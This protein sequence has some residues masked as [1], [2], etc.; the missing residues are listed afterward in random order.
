MV[1]DNTET[2]DVTKVKEVVSESAE[3]VQ[4]AVTDDEI[5]FNQK[6]KII[7]KSQIKT[8]NQQMKI[9]K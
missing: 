9:Q 5:V 4:N 8:L 3:D 7:L 1:I 2:E 6:Q